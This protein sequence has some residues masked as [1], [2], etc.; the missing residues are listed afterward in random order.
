M[1]YLYEKVPELVKTKP[2]NPIL[3]S[4]EGIDDNFAVCCRPKLR[5]VTS[6]PSN[7][8]P[9]TETKREANFETNKIGTTS[10]SLSQILK[11]SFRICVAN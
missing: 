4:G 2:Q 9:Q 8:A 6:E 7:R 10:D 3:V 11:N 5:R 1:S